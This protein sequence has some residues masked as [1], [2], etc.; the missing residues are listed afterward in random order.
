MY[1]KIISDLRQSYDRKVEERDRKELALWKD[2]ERKKFLSLL[3]QEG[4]SRL[5]EIGAGTGLYGKFF[6]DYGMQVVCTD[7]SPE[8]VQR[9]SQKGLE[10]Y[11]MDFLHLD[12]PE[13]SFDAVFA[14][15]CLLHVPQSD[16]PLTLK[17][18]HGLLRKNGLFYWGQ[19]GGVEQDGI[20][21]G[22][23]YEPKRYFSFITDEKITELV[24]ELFQV[25]SFKTIE[26]EEEENFHFQSMTVRKI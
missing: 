25:V 14:M 6:Q 13:N 9:C 20:Y 4:R 12:F 17:G 23:H 24:Q 2:Q 8:M 15:N 18:I 3:V 16:L 5:L 22:D 26:L 1:D 10:A 7:L 19:Y 11:V 21:E